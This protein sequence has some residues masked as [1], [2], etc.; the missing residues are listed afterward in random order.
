MKGAGRR[1]C[2]V[3]GCNSTGAFNDGFTLN[4]MVGTC[5][6]LPATLKIVMSLRSRDFCRSPI[7]RDLVCD[8]AITAF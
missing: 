6:S 1:I 7:A 4:Q 3:S 2:G 5:Y 8:V